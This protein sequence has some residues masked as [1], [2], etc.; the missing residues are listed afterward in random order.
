MT[1][2]PVLWQEDLI[3][4]TDEINTLY[5]SGLAETNAAT[6]PNVEDFT[7]INEGTSER[8]HFMLSKK[9]PCPN[10]L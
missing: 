6:H 10:D 5:I 2:A 8:D 7:V 4:C 1:S 9:R 3:Q